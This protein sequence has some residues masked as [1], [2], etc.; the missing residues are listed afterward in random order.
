ML[1][2][3][4]TKN[5]VIPLP[6]RSYD[7]ERLISELHRG[8]EEAA[9]AFHERYGARVSRFVWHLLGGDS[10]H[11]DLVQQV[12]VNLLSSIG[13]LK[14]VDSLDAWVDS[15][16]FRTVRKELRQRKVKRLFLLADEPGLFD[17]LA[18]RENPMQAVHIRSFYKVLDKMPIDERMM[19]IMRYLEGMTVDEIAA[20]ARFSHSTVKRRLKRALDRLERLASREIVLVSLMEGNCYGTD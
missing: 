11:D 5:N 18:A 3:P 16:I 13:T 1:P 8:K 10:E 6:S 7:N 15:V 4:K 17:E 20:A 9:A 14:K 19:I 2:L 12:F